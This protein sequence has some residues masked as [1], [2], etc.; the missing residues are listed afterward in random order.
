M[1][2]M[3]R[4]RAAGGVL[5]ALAVLVPA[6]PAAASEF[7]M[8]L[9]AGTRY[10]EQAAA[11]RA[12]LAEARPA[13]ARAEA[14]AGEL[15]RAWEAL[16]VEVARLDTEAQ[17]AAALVEAAR[18]VIAGVAAEAYINSGGSR[19]NAAL[20]VTFEA[21]DLLEVGWNL[22]MLAKSGSHEITEYEA[23]QAAHAAIVARLDD[24]ARRRAE[25]KEAMDAAVEHIAELEAAL[26]GARRE[27]HDALEGIAAFHR[28]AR[29]ADSPILG[30]SL[31]GADEMATFVRA[32]GGTTRLSI[33]L[34]ALAQIY[35]DEGRAAGVRGDV[36]FAQSIL[37][38]GWFR[39]E[40]SMVDP[41]D[42]NFA[43][44]GACDTCDDGFDFPDV[45]TGV[46]AQMRLLRI[47]VDAGLERDS[48]PVPLVMPRSLGLWFRGDVHTWRDLTG[49][50]ATADEYGDLLYELYRDM[51]AATR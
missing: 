29:T 40:H 44:I 14:R 42:N 8:P 23:L 25:T 35:L 43:G 19:V 16:T 48:L 30:P 39:F 27:L 5:A 9:D 17:H 45:R 28:A 2:T 7:P 41:E 10:V 37:E 50:W 33:A 12:T 49:R 3:R 1:T 36:A 15:R 51:V 32:R 6:S 22:H 38:T 4:M 31:L 34:G 20:D 13:I 26:A 24:T 47:Y 18:A 46:R 11:A 21:N